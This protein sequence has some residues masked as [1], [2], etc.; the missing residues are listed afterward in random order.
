MPLFRHQENIN[1]ALVGC[2]TVSYD[3]VK[4]MQKCQKQQKEHT[5]TP[6]ELIC[7]FD[8]GALILILTEG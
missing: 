3:S 1:Q 5:I 7:A 4:T 2:E 6:E 8:S